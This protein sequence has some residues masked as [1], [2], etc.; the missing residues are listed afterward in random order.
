MPKMIF[1]NLPVKNLAVATRF[2]KAIGCVKNERFSNE[3]VASMVW[4][5]TI[6]FHLL[7]RDYFATFSEKPVA[8]AKGISEVLLSLSC[9]S[10][11]EV[12][13]L[14]ETAAVSGGKADLREP[15]DLG[16]MY[17]RTFEDPD[18]HVLELVWMDASVPATSEQE[19]QLA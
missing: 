3:K 6:F 2:Y 16:F 1:V 12:D 7:T 8:D 15:L 19:G 13:T 9:D 5:D 14:T 10:R 4:S 18:G 17:N 11:E